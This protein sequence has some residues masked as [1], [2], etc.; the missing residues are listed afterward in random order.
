MNVEPGLFE[1]LAWYP[2]SMPD[3]LTTSEMIQTGFNITKDYS[4][5][6]PLD[7]LKDNQESIEQFYS[8]SFSVTQNILNNTFSSGTLI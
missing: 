1:W 3:W 5:I 2:D 8:R 6:V 4:P 7:E